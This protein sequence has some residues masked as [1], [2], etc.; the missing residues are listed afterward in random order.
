MEKQKAKG[1]RLDRKRFQG[2]KAETMRGIIKHILGKYGSIEG[3]LDGIGFDVS[4]REE[5]RR[6]VV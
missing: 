4:W 6:A 3:Y 2:A 5:L 1:P